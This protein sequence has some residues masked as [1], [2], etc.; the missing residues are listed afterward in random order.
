MLQDGIIVRVAFDHRAGGSVC[1]DVIFVGQRVWFVGLGGGH[2][3][4]DQ[5]LHG[6]GFFGEDIHFQDPFDDIAHGVSFCVA[7]VLA[8]GGEAN[9]KFAPSLLRQMSIEAAVD[10]AKDRDDAEGQQDEKPSQDRVGDEGIE[11]LIGEVI[12]IIKRV[13]ALLPGGKAGKEYQ[14][15][16]MEQKDRLV[17]IGGPGQPQHCRKGDAAKPGQSGQPIGCGGLNIAFG[18]RPQRAIEDL[19]GIGG[20]VEKEHDQ[21]PQPS[22]GEGVEKCVLALKRQ[23]QKISEEELD[24]KR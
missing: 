14:S 8:G 24:E 3:F 6:S 13:A 9:A 15:R 20:G 1:V 17:G 22:G 10:G 18:D 19:G 16:G 21:G 11:G 7:P 23:K 12:G 2:H 5:R 4:V